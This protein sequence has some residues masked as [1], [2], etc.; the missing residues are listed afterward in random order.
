MLLWVF[1]KYKDIILILVF[2]IINLDKYL[3]LLGFLELGILPFDFINEPD[4]YSSQAGSGSSFP[5]GSG[6]SFPEGS[7]NSGGGGH[8]QH[9]FRSESGT[10]EDNENTSSSKPKSFKERLLAKPSESAPIN[11]VEDAINHIEALK[12]RENNL[13]YMIA[14]HPNISRDIRL[15]DLDINFKKKPLSNIAKYLDNCRKMD[16]PRS[17]I[18]YKSSP[19]NTPVE[20]ILRYLRNK[21]IFNRLIKD[22][23]V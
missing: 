4:N 23:H 7:G 16:D 19:G 17:R 6:S 5:E 15:R 3:A 18:F 11:T 9:I 13:R 14:Q 20:N 1:L 21:L 2:I 22:F 8:E 10:T 12:A